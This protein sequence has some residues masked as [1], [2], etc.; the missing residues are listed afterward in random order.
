M[1]EEA[2]LGALNELERR[3]ITVPDE[4]SVI[5]IATSPG[6]NE[7]I[8]PPPTTMHA[9]SARLGRLGVRMLVSLLDESADQQPTRLVSCDFRPGKSTGPAPR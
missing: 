9:P 5:S 8:S 7:R 4:F 1:N 2:S 3:G 6:V